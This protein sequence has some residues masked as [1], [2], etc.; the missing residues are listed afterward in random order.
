MRRGFT[1]V[2]LLVVIILIAVLASIAV[3]IFGRNA[4]ISKENSLRYQL[5]QLRDAQQKYFA[6]YQGWPDDIEDFTDLRPSA[7][8][9]FSSTY[10]EPW[11]SR[12]YFGP[13]L[14]QGAS[15]V[16][17]WIKDPVSG[18]NFSTSRLSNG[19]LQIRSSASGRDSNGVLFST[20]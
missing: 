4:R 20:Y 8:I 18:G 16:E 3:P 7:R 11:G 15:R 10:N 9:W 6:L 19:E 17:V 12:P 5:R 1:L 14:I 13:L 2:E